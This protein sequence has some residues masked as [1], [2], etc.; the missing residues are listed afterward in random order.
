MDDK[1][2]E[3]LRAVLDLDPE[4]TSALLS[5]I[6]IEIDQ[7]SQ[8]SKAIDY[9][10]SL[11]NG[12]VFQYSDVI[13]A[14]DIVGAIEAAKSDIGSP[15][16]VGKLLARIFKLW[17]RLRE[18]RVPVTLPEIKVIKAI[19]KGHRTSASMAN[20]LKISQDDVQKSLDSLMGKSYGS[21]RVSLVEVKDGAYSTVF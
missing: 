20:H 18:I 10:I 15:V 9:S 13:L 1:F 14:D 16:T 4:I 3:T 8:H 17:T 5:E 19:R 7:G 6:A 21:Q 11:K 12:F 2:Q